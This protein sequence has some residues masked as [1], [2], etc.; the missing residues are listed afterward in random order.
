M[1]LPLGGQFLVNK[2]HKAVCDGESEAHS[3]DRKRP[4]RDDFEEF[5]KVIHGAHRFVLLGI[6][7][8]RSRAINSLSRRTF[9]RYRMSM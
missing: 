9:A 4:H 1:P 8:K 6:S 5:K 7:G 3:P 2:Q